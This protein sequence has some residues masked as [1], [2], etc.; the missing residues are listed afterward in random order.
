MGGKSKTQH[1]T[2]VAVHTVYI[3]LDILIVDATVYFVYQ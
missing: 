1:N 2:V 3:Q